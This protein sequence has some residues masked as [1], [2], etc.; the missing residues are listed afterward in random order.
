[1]RAGMI[2]FRRAIETGGQIFARAGHHPDKQRRKHSRLPAAISENFQ[3]PAARF[4]RHCCKSAVGRGAGFKL[5]HQADGVRQ[6]HAVFQQQASD[7]A[8]RETW[9]P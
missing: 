4:V 6:R 1:M 3:C 5:F 8:M 7:E 2:N 9:L